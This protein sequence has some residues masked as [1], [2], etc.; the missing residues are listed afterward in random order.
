MGWWHDKQGGAAEVTGNGKQA[1]GRGRLA[2]ETVVV[3]GATSGLGKDVCVLCAAEGARVVISG[4]NQERGDQVASLVAEAGGDAVFVAADLSGESGVTELVDRAHEAFGPV[5]VLVNNV[6]DRG[7]LRHDGPLGNVNWETWASALAANLISVAELSRLLLPDMLAAG[8]G[9]II[10][11]TS[12]AAGLGHP[13]LAIYSAC[14]AGLE[15]LARQISADYGRLG[16]RANVIQPGNLAHET[17]DAQFPE[18]KAQLEA[19]SATRPVQ[20][21]DVALAIVYLASPESEG[22]AGVVLPVDSGLTT[23]IP[24]SIYISYGGKAKP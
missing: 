1:E 12:T 21:R 20:A 9:S 13:G 17:R 3:T 6:V 23:I 8:H 16:V 14:K 19:R 5:T 4:R 10:N 15:G 18:R 22:I 2:G 7:S 11:V 24:D